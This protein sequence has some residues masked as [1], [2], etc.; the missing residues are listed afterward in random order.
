M[1]KSEL[2]TG[3]SPTTQSLKLIL[4]LTKNSELLNTE[5][6]NWSGTTI[7]VDITLKIAFSKGYDWIIK[8]VKLKAEL[9]SLKAE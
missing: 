7:A 8:F 9:I 4:K 6:F 3:I 2:K 1:I 5:G